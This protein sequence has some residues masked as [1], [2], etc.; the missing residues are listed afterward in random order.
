MKITYYIV[1]AFLASITQA[2]S[3]RPEWDN[4]GVLQVNR[5]QPHATMM[6]YA[7][8]EQAA[9]YQFEK[10]TYHVSLNGLWKFK[11]SKNPAQRPV[12]F[13]K[14]SFDASRWDNLEVPSNWEM[15][16]Y[17][18]RIYTNNIYPFNTE[19]LRAPYDDNPV[20]S[21]RREIEVPE[22]WDGRQVYINFGAVESAFYLWIN[23]EKVGYSQGS[24]TPAE[25]NIT[26]Y[27]KKGK[28]LIAAEVY[29]WSDGSY[30]E[31]QDFW[32]L[33]GIFR[34]VYLWSTPTVHIR[35]FMV[36]SSL[37]DSYTK[38]VFRLTGEISNAG[39]DGKATLE[40]EITDP[41]GKSF[42]SETKEL[43]LSGV[44][45]VFTTKTAAFK[46]IKPWNAEQPN[47][48]R[49]LITL[50]DENGK[51]LEVIPQ[52]VGFRRVEIKNGRFMVN[53][54]QVILKGANRHEHNPVTGHYVTEQDMMNDIR[55]LKQ[56]NFNAVRTSHYPN[57]PKWYDLCDEYGIYLI[58]EG[59]IE[60][61]GFGND[62]K[63]ILSNM[64]EWKE[65]YLDRV[66]RMVHRDKN[67]PS[68]VIW[69]MGN[70]SGDGP[71]VK[72]TY[73]W[74]R[75]FDPSRPF[76]YE[77]SKDPKNINADMLSR[78]YA[79]IDTSEKI[80]KEH[81]NIPYMLCEYTHAMGNS[82]GNLKEYWD[83]LYAD[84]NFFGA[85]VWDWMDQGMKQPVPEAYR[86]TSAKDYFFAYGGWWEE[87]V[88]YHHDNN[89]CMNG[90]L[91]ADLIPHPGMLALKYQQRFVHIKP[92]DF[93]RGEFEIKNWHDFINLNEIVE[94]TWELLENGI[95]VKTGA[96][97][98]LDVDARTS[99]KIRI[100]LQEYPRKENA[101]YLITFN[102]TLKEK[103]FYA[104]KGYLM[105]WDQFPLPG[106]SPAALVPASSNGQ[107]KATEIVDFRKH[108]T[109]KGDNF[110][111]RFN[112]IDGTL[113]AYYYK[114]QRII[115]QGPLPDF[116]RALTDN[117]IGSMRDGKY[118]EQ[119]VLDWRSA[120]DWQLRDFTAENI[121]DGSVKVTFKGYL[122]VPAMEMSISYIVYGDGSMDVEMNY[123]P[124]D[125]KMAIMPRLGT[126]LTLAPG[127]D[128]LTWYGP[129]PQPTYQD[130]NFEKVGVYNSTVE[131]QWIDYSRPQENGYKTNVRWVD[132]RNKA[133]LGLRFS[134]DPLIGVGAAH[135]TK[136][137][138]L[139]SRYSFQLV[140]H[141]EVFVN[142]D[143][144]QV[145][146]GGTNSWSKGGL[147]LEEYRIKNEPVVFRYRIQPVDHEQ[148]FAN[149]L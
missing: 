129:G 50:K 62:K 51:L 10:S 57:D 55:L 138:I 18:T 3:Q 132:F 93:A 119:S 56:H 71:N 69:S 92:V 73:E 147:A 7:A 142:I 9:S 101:E 59:N 118:H 70:E 140:K 43:Q 108:Y 95:P 145:G 34:D 8:R 49:L 81:D 32:R 82:N 122:P 25:F 131:E 37:D 126:Q 124:G 36:S 22:I 80:I 54:R 115:D 111:A 83:L 91:G 121:K 48:Y 89:F 127:F 88:G 47:L 19:G 78:M 90:V 35:D 64:P 117:D 2:K 4:V 102:S 31:D 39:N 120:G 87:Q 27:L 107:A 123:K 46:K 20:G 143:Y 17:G 148:S 79:S 30:L 24:R 136:D 98:N 125:K 61:H 110:I 29:R 12:D 97:A 66:Q 112:K 149:G 16:G 96:V 63:N 77:G 116:W 103:T 42:Y 26:R 135:H 67:H 15:K 114:N 53:G 28:N 68:V 21:Y 86:A 45:T 74:T 146:V 84:N 33:S 65:A 144:A 137:E 5:E 109:V 60:T 13:Y 41:Q 76:H 134:G 52:K 58:D 14:S 133:G 139:R 72:A 40:I 141:P 105:A 104:E 38:G 113:E 99:K 75:N 94:V 6:V 23:G 100:E 11:W 44:K 85:F 128:Q 1:L 106:S 130:R